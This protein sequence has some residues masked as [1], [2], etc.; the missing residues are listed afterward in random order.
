M[1]QLMAASLF[2]LALAVGLSQFLPPAVVHSQTMFQSLNSPTGLVGWWRLCGDTSATSGCVASSST[3]AYDASGYGN[4]GSWSGTQTGATGWYSAGKVGPWA[5]AFDGSTDYLA[6]ADATILKPASFTVSAWIYMTANT[7]AAVYYPIG[8]CGTGVCSSGWALGVAG[9][10][11]TLTGCS[12]VTNGT[13]YLAAMGSGNVVCTTATLPL[14]TWVFIAA[15][16]SSGTAKL[17]INGSSQSTTGSTGAFSQAAVPFSIGIANTFYFPGRIDDVRL[18][19]RA[20]SAGEIA[21]MA[22]AHD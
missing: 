17:Y 12:G 7:T 8:K 11:H 1:K 4:N 2:A 19:N 15:T 6:V 9:T 18:Y 3:A 13:L 21:Q 16:Y 5:G 14:N 22:L 20:L 10:F